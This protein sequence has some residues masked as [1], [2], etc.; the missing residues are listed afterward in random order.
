MDTIL[1]VVGRWV[2]IGAAAYWLAVGFYL[3]QLSRAELQIDGKTYVSYSAQIARVSKLGMG[4]AIASGLTVLAGFALF[5]IERYWNRPLGSVGAI[6][7]YIGILVGFA[8]SVHG[9][10]VFGKANRQTAAILKEVGA[11]PTDGQVNALR[12]LTSGLLEKLPLHFG[13]VAVAF[14]TMIAGSTIA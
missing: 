2:H 11:T 4:M 3:W 6:I 13:M 10:M 9:G 1:V 8:A 14:L 7:F 5:G 12:E